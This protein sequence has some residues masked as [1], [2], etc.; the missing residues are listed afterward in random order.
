MKESN[1][2]VHHLPSQDPVLELYSKPPGQVQMKLPSVSTHVPP[3]QILGK[4]H[5]LIFKREV[6]MGSTTNPTPL[7]QRRW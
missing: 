3:T 7:G 6:V 1:D 5:S 2:K 4:L